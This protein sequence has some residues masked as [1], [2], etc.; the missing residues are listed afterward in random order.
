MN[1]ETKQIVASNLTA[2]FYAA[3][4]GRPKGASLNPSGGIDHEAIVATYRKFVSLIE[5]PACEERRKK[6]RVAVG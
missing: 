2:A 5:A 1:E 6:G 4:S 3:Q